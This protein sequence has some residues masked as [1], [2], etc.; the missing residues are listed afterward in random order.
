MSAVSL[1]ILGPRVERRQLQFFERF[2]PPGW[3]QARA[4]GNEPSLDALADDGV[5]SCSQADLCG[6]PVECPLYPQKRTLISTVMMSATSRKPA[7]VRRHRAS[8]V[9][10]LLRMAT[11]KMDCERKFYPSPPLWQ[12]GNPRCLHHAEGI[13]P[14]LQFCPNSA[15]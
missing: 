9:R 7:I 1:F 12:R 6:A 11:I 10:P 4:H 5:D 8:A 13:G 15:S 2:R 14:W 3:R